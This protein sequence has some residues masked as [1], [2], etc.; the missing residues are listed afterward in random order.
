M[1]NAYVLGAV[2]LPKVDQ[3]LINRRAKVM[4]PAYRLFYQRPLHLVRG[5][6][7]WLY[8]AD[9]TKYLDVYNNVA[10]VGH[11]HPHV[12][13]AI[14]D[15]AGRLCTHTRYLTAEPIDFA[16]RL[17]ASFPSEI[18]HVMFTNS[19]SEANDLALRLAFDATGGTGVIISSNAYHGTTHLIAG[20]SPSLGAGVPAYKNTWYVA[21]PIDGDGLAFGERIT[22]ALKEMQ[23]KGVKPAALLIDSIF[24]SDGVAAEPAGFLATAFNVMHKAKALVIADEVQPGFGRTGSGMWCFARHG[25]VPDMVTMGKPM[26]NGYPIAALALRP[27]VIANFGMKARYFNTFAGNSVA[28]AAANAVFD[29]IENQDLIANS[30]KVGS[31]MAEALRQTMGFGVV[32]AA[33]LMVAVDIVNQ[34]G[35]ADPE[36]ATRLV[37]QLAQHGVLISTSRK[38]GSALKIRPPLTFSMAHL[39]LFLDKLTLC[40]KNERNGDS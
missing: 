6:D 14:A 12:V 8:G 19:G 39:D 27:E 37:N 26:G 29:V 13:H 11:S 23:A 25:V 2:D 20:L 33:G 17:V 28:I 3:D 21:P 15:Q 30:K 35:A 1:L 5:E 10:S 22:S 16:E 36:R 31:A 7:V 18:G 38:D 24:T 4:G 32:R 9:G 40:L 34:N